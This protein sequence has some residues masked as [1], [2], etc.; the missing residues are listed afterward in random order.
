MSFTWFWQ[1]LMPP[2]LM[3]EIDKAQKAGKIKETL[4]SFL[5]MKRKK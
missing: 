5:K 2:L 3:D 4:E 1:D